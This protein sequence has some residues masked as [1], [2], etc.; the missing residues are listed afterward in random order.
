MGQAFSFTF[1]IL[2]NTKGFIVSMVIMPIL[3]ILLVSIT[4]AYSDAPVVGYIGEKAPNVAGVKMVRLVENESDYFLGLGQGTLVIRTD[5]EGNV[6]K[7]YS[8][9][10]DNSL[11]S[12]IENADANDKAFDERPKLRYSVGIILFKL[13]TAGG[14][15]ATVL[16]NE[17]ENGIILRIKN[18][19]TRLGSYILG[20]SLAIIFVYEI[21][22][23][24][25]LL[26]YKFAGFDLGKTDII[27]LG[28][29]FTVT[30]LISTGLYIFLSAV[31]KNEGYIWVISTGVIFP[32]GLV[33]GVLFPVEYMAD[34][35]KL[36]AHMS[37]IYYLQHYI[38][39]GKIDVIPILLMLAAALTLGIFGTVLIGKR[40]NYV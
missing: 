27:Q 33:S 6:E 23:F 40:K 16:I 13:L 11:I 15:L 8:S 35:M 17:K 18:S 34:W 28:T 24:L 9:I 22:N 19:K 32:L 26:F 36:V 25:I 1:K 2:K 31:M 3:M 14:L 4:L 38:I 30:L 10:A 5:A 37:P 29:L 39:H 20:K 21:A 7:Y 12:V